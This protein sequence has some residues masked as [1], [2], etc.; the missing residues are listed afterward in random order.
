MVV[1]RGKAVVGTG[2]LNRA[3]FVS[4]NKARLAFLEVELSFSPYHYPNA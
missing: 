2:V 4:P 1:D 3:L